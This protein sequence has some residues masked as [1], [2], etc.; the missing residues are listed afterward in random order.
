MLN[1]PMES[2]FLPFL[3]SIVTTMFY[4]LSHEGDEGDERSPEAL[5]NDLIYR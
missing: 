1:G 4:P 5:L 3:S 2:D